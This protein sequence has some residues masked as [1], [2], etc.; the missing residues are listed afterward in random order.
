LVK[1]HFVPFE[2]QRLGFELNRLD[3][4]PSQFADAV[5]FQLAASVPLK[6]FLHLEGSSHY[7]EDTNTPNRAPFHA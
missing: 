3:C 6:S 7:H 1:L 2:V 4:E 5:I